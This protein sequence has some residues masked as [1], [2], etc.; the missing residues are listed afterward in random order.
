MGNEGSLEGGGQPGD[1]G[2]ISMAGA[3]GSIS[4]PPGSGQHI[5]PVNGAAAG[6]GI[7]GGPGIGMNR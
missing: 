4:A 3:P 7:G 1:P 5:K 2:S 6:G